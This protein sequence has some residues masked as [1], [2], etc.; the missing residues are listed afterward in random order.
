MFLSHT[1]LLYYLFH[2]VLLVLH[3]VGCTA[4]PPAGE[5]KRHLVPPRSTGGVVVSV[6]LVGIQRYLGTGHY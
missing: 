6:G 3:L 2:Y 1:P 4:T 5:C